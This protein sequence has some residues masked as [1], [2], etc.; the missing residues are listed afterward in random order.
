M[1]QYTVK[2]YGDKPGLLHSKTWL[3]FHLSYL[4]LTDA[5][6]D[7][8]KRKIHILDCG[9]KRYAFLKIRAEY[10]GY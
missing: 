1:A 4:C 9:R 5:E 10:E 6:F 2:G 7:R 3:W 8:E